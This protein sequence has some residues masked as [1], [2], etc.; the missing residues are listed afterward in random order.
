MQ[1][2][3]PPAGGE[4]G[5]RLVGV[6]H[7]GVQV[8]DR[9]HRD[10]QA[11]AA[12]QARQRRLGAVGRRG[13]R[14]AVVRGHVNAAG[15][16]GHTKGHVGGGEQGLR[17]GA[18]SGRPGHAGASG[19]LRPALPGH[20]LHQPFGDELGNVGEHQGG[21]LVAAQAPQ[22]VVATEGRLHRL[23]GPDQ[24]AVPGGVSKTLVHRAELVEVEGDHG[25]RALVGG[26]LGQ[27]VHPRP[28]GLAR[29]KS[30]Q[31]V[32]GGVMASPPQQL[33]RFP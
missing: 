3:L 31:G 15:A 29:E 23:A 22:H 33:G 17:A 20:G 6:G 30:R 25:R 24:Q 4:A 11:L 21:E 8:H 32:V 2:P 13:E 7:A 14:G 19:A 26:Q 18:V 27:L 28:E 9:L 5:Q 10:A 16:L 12:A 1:R